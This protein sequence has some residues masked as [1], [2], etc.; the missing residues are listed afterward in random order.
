MLSHHAGLIYVMVLVSAADGDMTDAEMK[1]IG[2]IIGFLPVF[3][4]YDPSLLL[5]TTAACAE[6]LDADDGME[7]AL[8]FIRASV[9]PALRETAY[10][11]ACDV[12]ASDGEGHPETRRLMEMLRHR[13]DVDRLIAAAI[14]RGATARFIR[15]TPR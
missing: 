3:A 15:Q 12:A 8:E 13:L 10:A 2:E 1:T 11:L 14:E 6:L 9:P 5:K 4:D 7:R